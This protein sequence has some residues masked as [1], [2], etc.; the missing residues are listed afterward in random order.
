MKKLNLFRSCLLL[1]VI[2]VFAYCS[3]DGDTGPQGPAGPAGPAGPTGTQGPK[4]DTGTANVIYSSWTDTANWKPDTVMVGSVVTDTLGYF[5]NISAPKLTL[6]ILNTG[7]IKVY[8]NLSDDPNFPLVFPLPY[9]NGSVFIDPVF[10]PNTI[11]LYSNA[12]LD[13]LP[14]RYI[15]IPGKVPARMATVD[16]NNYDAV[17][18][19]LGLKD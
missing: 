17:K 1:A 10:F 11:Q 16:W 18:K 14:I 4:G 6:N 3:K 12:E 19:Y 13:G 8:V 2:L 7:E 9:N 15:L 5:A